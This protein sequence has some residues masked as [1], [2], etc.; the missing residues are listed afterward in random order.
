M[1]SVVEWLDW[2]EIHKKVRFARKVQIRGI[3]SD[4]R[5]RQCKNTKFGRAVCCKQKIVSAPRCAGAT[6]VPTAPSLQ[7]GRKSW[8]DMTDE[9]E[10]E[11]RNECSRRVG[12]E[13]TDG[14]GQTDG[15]D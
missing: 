1:E 4:N 12:E 6:A 2:E 3:P 7:G 14:R 10:R 15:L 11:R 5:G 13:Q 9:E 8:A